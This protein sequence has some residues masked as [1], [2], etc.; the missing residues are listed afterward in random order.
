MGTLTTNHKIGGCQRCGKE[1]GFYPSL[2]GSSPSMCYSCQADEEAA[3]FPVDGTKE[4]TF[5]IDDLAD[6]LL[7]YEY[8]KVPDNMKLAKERI[9]LALTQLWFVRRNP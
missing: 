2:D 1:F 8:R 6:I 7:T 5:K 3:N 9:L 4:L